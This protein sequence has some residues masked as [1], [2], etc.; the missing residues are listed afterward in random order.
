MA[1]FKLVL[2]PP[3]ASVT[4]TTVL[5]SL[6]LVSER[7]DALPF[8]REAIRRAGGKVEDKSTSKKAAS[9][10]PEHLINIP[11]GINPSNLANYT[12]YDVLGFTPEWADSADHEAIK[13]AYHK[14]VLM[15]HP[16]KAQ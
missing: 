5:A 9:A 1:S 6:N 13:R 16:D 11:E 10:F 12:Y 8:G 4:Q 14:A 2:G 3:P 7:V 15:Y